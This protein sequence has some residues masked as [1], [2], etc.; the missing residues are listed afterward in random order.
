[1][2]RLLKAVP[3][4]VWSA[5]V[6]LLL[7]KETATK[8][9]FYWKQAAPGDF[10]LSFLFFISFITITL[11]YARMQVNAFIKLEDYIHVRKKEKKAG[12]VM[13]RYS[14][15]FIKQLSLIIPFFLIREILT[16]GTIQSDAIL[17]VFSFTLNYAIVHFLYYL[18]RLFWNHDTINFFFFY[19]VCILLQVVAQEFNFLAICT[20]YT[21]Y[22][23]KNPLVVLITKGG[24]LVLTVLC[25]YMKLTK[26]EWIG[27]R[28]ND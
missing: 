13:K 27:D 16:H 11:N 20:A 18:F 22:L 3:L 26:K 9:I 15:Q 7:Q 14:I 5:F 8:S 28:I 21:P 2:Y 17:F 12:Y 19:I 10:F 25:L 24:I 1:M 23:D 4:T 6:F